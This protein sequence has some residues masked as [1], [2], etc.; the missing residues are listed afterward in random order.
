MRQIL[1]LALALLVSASPATAQKLHAGATV[2]LVGALACDTRDQAVSILAAIA[3]HG[4]AAGK[5]RFH[6]LNRQR[7]ALNEPVCGMVGSPFE[8]MPLTLIGKVATFP[9]LAFGG[10]E[11]D[12]YIVEARD[13]TD[14][15]FF[16]ITFRDAHP[17]APEPAA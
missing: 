3:E 10:V 17:P 16:I 1:L 13:G 5:A 14:A 15:P 11:R 12:T 6:E 2:N 8:P 7:N 4:E 9:M